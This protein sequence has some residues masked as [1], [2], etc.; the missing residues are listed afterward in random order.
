KVLSSLSVDHFIKMTNFTFLNRRGLR[1][2]RETVT[3]LA[4]YEGFPQHGKAVELRFK[5]T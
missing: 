2:L 1:S 4:E 3:G 5:R